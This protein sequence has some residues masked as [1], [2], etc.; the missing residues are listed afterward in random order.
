VEL[1][2]L[3]FKHHFSTAPAPAPE[4][5]DPIEKVLTLR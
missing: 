1:P 4:R 2:A 3:R 5:A